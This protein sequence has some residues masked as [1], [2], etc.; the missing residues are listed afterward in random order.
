[1]GLT[2]FC[3]ATLQRMILTRVGKMILKYFYYLI[4]KPNFTKESLI[5]KA[6]CPSDIFLLNRTCVL[7]LLDVTNDIRIFQIMVL[8]VALWSCGFLWILYFKYLVF[9]IWHWLFGLVKSLCYHILLIWV[10][11]PECLSLIYANYV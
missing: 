6:S 2:T 1:M 11:D 9:F 8:F 7:V 4:S 10:R 3:C 5:S